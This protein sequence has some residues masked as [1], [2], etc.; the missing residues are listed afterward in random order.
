VLA[1]KEAALIWAAHGVDVGAAKADDRESVNA[2]SLTVTFG[3]TPGR[4]MA[5][6]SLGSIQFVNGVPEPAI[7]LYP[8]A[9][10][11]LV[12]AM[13]SATFFVNSPGAIRDFILGRVLGRALAHEIGHFLLRS[14]HHSTVG[15]MR[16]F[17][18][19]ADLVDPDRRHFG[20]SDGDVTRLVAMTSLFPRPSGLLCGD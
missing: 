16:A 1:L 9:I 19:T 13:P 4:G 20:L 3:N 8:N 10:G 5:A 6:A 15:L 14:L 18:P 12:S 2:V 11:A 7:V 17:Q